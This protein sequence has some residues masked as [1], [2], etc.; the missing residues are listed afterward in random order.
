MKTMQT[1]K[2][3][4]IIYI[5]KKYNLKSERFQEITLE[6]CL[7]NNRMKRELICYDKRLGE[8]NGL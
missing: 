2:A 6:F 8:K 3:H 5:L 4:G 1:L 7:K